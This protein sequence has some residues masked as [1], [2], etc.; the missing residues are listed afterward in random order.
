MISDMEEA[1]RVG[2]T[3]AA[4]PASLH[5]PL[6]VESSISSLVPPAWQP[7]GI[8]SV[9]PPVASGV[10]CDEG[11]VLRSAGARVKDLV[12]GLDRFTATE[13]QTHEELDAFG[14]PLTRDARRSEY[15][16]AISQPTGQLNLQEFRSDLSGLGAF[17]D[18]ISTRGLL[19]LA[20]VF[21]SNLQKDYRFTCEGLGDWK[22]QTTW[23]VH[24]LQLSNNGG[25]LQSF[26]IGKNSHP[27]ALK[28]RAWIRA[29]DY[30]ILHIEAELAGPMPEIEL[31]SEHQI[32]DYGPVDFPA[33][34]LQLWLPQQTEIYLDLRGHRYR[35]SNHYTDF[36][37]FSVDSNQKVNLRS[38]TR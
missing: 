31:Q 37:L 35:F 5:S 34:K 15:V 11:Q 8:D 6:P 26:D 4:K 23:L 18:R 20:F 13:I 9:R 27:V 12:D 29:A 7:P 2:Q 38:S 33:K 32:A 16:V 1:L 25:R 19:S 30:Q 21:H 24:F 22:G 10:S 36:K 3:A 14:K 28:G 17:P